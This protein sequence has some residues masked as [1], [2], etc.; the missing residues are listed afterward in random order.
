MPKISPTLAEDARAGLSAL[1][2]NL[3]VGARSRFRLRS[4]SRQR[5]D[6]RGSRKL[7]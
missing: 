1:G 3:E 5:R 6:N 2:V 7:P 4:A